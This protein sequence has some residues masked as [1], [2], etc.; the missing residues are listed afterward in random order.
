MYCNDI[1]ICMLLI[2]SYCIPKI[3]IVEITLQFNRIK[4]EPA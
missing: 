1:I 3:S 2:L 4:V